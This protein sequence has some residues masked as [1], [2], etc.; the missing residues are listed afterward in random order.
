MTKLDKS[1][2]AEQA[3]NNLLVSVEIYDVG[4]GLIKTV[5]TARKHDPA[6]F[7]M[8]DTGETVSNRVYSNADTFTA[9][10]RHMAQVQ[11]FIISLGVKPDIISLH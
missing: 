6:L 5:Y 1:K 9:P 8:D 10:L 2:H 7:L 3:N 4:N 11:N